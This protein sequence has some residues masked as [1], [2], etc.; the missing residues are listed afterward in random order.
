MTLRPEDCTLIKQLE[1][2]LIAELDRQYLNDEIAD[3][4]TGAV[5]FDAVD[6]ELVG[7]PDWFKALSKV[8][9][10]YWDEEGR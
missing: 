1:D 6:G 3:D 4:S 7:K 5:Y 10:A 9:E 2:V 8:I